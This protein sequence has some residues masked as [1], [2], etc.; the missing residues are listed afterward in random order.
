MPLTHCKHLRWILLLSCFFYLSLWVVLA[1]QRL[2]LYAAH[3]AV[4][5]STLE[6]V[7]LSPLGITVGIQ[8]NTDGVM[9]VG[10]TPVVDR[11]GVE[12][13]PTAAL[14]VGDTLVFANNQRLQTK[15]DLTHLIH[16]HDT[17]SLVLKR[18]NQL[19]NLELTPVKDAHGHNKL[20]L[21]IKD[22]A[23][24][25]GT[26]T[27]YNPESGKFGALGH[28]II[29]TNTKELLGINRGEISLTDIETI[30][31]GKKGRPG[32]LV[33][34][35]ISTNTHPVDKAFGTIDINTQYGIFGYLNHDLLAY[36]KP[37]PIGRANT[38]QTGEALVLSNIEGTVQAYTASI[39]S[40]NKN[41][42][43][44]SKGMVVKITDQDLI[45][46]TNGIVQ[47]MSGSPII[48]N[49]RLIGAVTHVFVQDPTKGYGVFIEHMLKQEQG[50]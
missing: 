8:V 20:G 50:V 17:L 7:Y 24:G 2:H 16:V 14:Q 46:R 21:W 42:T 34:T 29:D 6:D 30:K 13:H 35:A 45:Q 39:E 28:G 40:V 47:G 12:H 27:Y 19:I 5:A 48:Q 37:M 41:T 4:L 36:H 43:D 49:G 31:K 22:M 26:V 3:P 38:I 18:D 23:Q 11:H 33:G 25:I 10:T 15:E 1:G 32:E 44:N 9:V